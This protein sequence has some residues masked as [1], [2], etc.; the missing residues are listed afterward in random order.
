MWRRTTPLFVIF[1]AILAFY[2]RTRSSNSIK[3]VRAQA[4]CAAGNDWL[5]ANPPAP[6]TNRPLS[7]GEQGTDCPFYQASWQQ[8]L[9][10]MQPNTSGQPRFLSSYLTIAEL[11]PSAAVPQ[12][13]FAKRNSAIAHARTSISVL[14]ARPTHDVLMLAPRSLQQ[15]NDTTNMGNN[16]A[17]DDGVRQAVTG[18]LLI[19]QRGNPIY[20]AIHVNQAFAAFLRNNNLNSVAAVA[21]NP[22]LTFPNGV[23]EIKSAWQIV[24]SNH[25]P[26]GYFVTKAKV[27][28]LTAKSGTDV[29]PDGTLRD[30][31]V[32]LIAIHIA[33]TMEGHPEMIWSTF[34]HLGHDCSGNV[35]QDNVPSLADLPGKVSD[36]VPVSPCSW[37]LYKANTTKGQSNNTPSTSTLVSAFDE[38]SQTFTKSGTT[39]QTSIV[40]SFP[41]SKQ[42]DPKPDDELTALNQS[43][44]GA[45]QIPTEANDVRRNYQLVGAVWMDDPLGGHPPQPGLFK[46]GMKIKNAQGIGP[47]TPG[48]MNAGEDGLSSVAM[49]SFSQTD[50]PNC[51]SC[52]DTQHTRAG[53]INVPAST[54]NVSHVL[55]KYLSTL[56]QPALGAGPT[57]APTR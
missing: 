14:A 38:G 35:A 6:S 7:H 37:N 48:A 19:D 2:S 13:M 50:S 27:P 55:S 54:L 5:S 53:G 43:M 46:A 16:P 1:L 51:F 25:P 26:A 36:D 24:D 49:E 29:A 17:I 44:S 8:F 10:A 47:D 39:L 30:V 57:A 3:S 42:D 41:G 11:L 18:G 28:R 21:A 22:T 52:H 4:T 34:D 31:T 33:F 15:P 56:P 12:R 9:Y 45:F 23:V 32:A 40:R 20:Y